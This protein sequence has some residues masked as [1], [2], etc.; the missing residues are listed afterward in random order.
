MHN[1]L[2]LLIES[3]ASIRVAMQKIN[4]N[5]RGLAFVLDEEKLVGVVSDGDVRRGLLDGYDLNDNIKN[6]MKTDFVRLSLGTSAKE[7]RRHF[8][9]EIKIIPLLD[10]N[11]KLS[12]F[13]DLYR[14]HKIPILEPELNGNE[15]DYVLNCLETSWISSLGSYVEQFEQKFAEL[16]PPMYALSVANGTVALHLALDA[17]GVTRGDEVILPN[18]TFAACINAVLYCGAKPVLCEIDPETLC[19]DPD[20]VELLVSSKTKAI[21]PVHLY[22]QPCDMKSILTIAKRRKLKVIEDCAEAVGS[23]IDGKSVGTFGDAATF[24]F[25]GNKTISTGEGGMVLFKSKEDFD[26][27]KIKQSHGMSPHK[28]YWHEVIGYNYRLTNM[29]SAIGVAQLERIDSIIQKKLW[30]AEQYDALL[31]GVAG[32]KKLPPRTNGTVHSNWLYT[33]ILEENVN[34][35]KVMDE[36]MKR[37]VDVRPVFYPLHTMPPYSKCRTSNSL[38]NSINVSSSGVSLPSS[39]SLEMNEIRLIVSSLTDILVL[40]NE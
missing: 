29:Q 27:A 11:G 38:T 14:S 28:K 34:R 30:V 25:F 8:S 33:I 6:I 15:I 35:D 23:K 20:Q 7:I 39:C 16:H 26:K 32:I 4:Q 9:S 37:G 12:D 5:M 1:Y 40:M 17:L 36:L 22:G 31:K 2:D 10:S 19:I 18:T 13:A 24:S 3:S 21:M